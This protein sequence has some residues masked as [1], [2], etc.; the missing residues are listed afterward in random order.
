MS[1]LS[2]SL[3]ELD[4]N[5]IIYFKNKGNNE[6]LLHEALIEK[7]IDFLS[8]FS[9]FKDTNYVFFTVEPTEDNLLDIKDIL[10]DLT[11]I[12]GIVPLHTLDVRKRLTH[13]SNK[14]IKGVYYLPSD[15][16]LTELAQLTADPNLAFYYSFFIYYQRW[17]FVLACV[18]G[19]TRYHP[20]N[21]KW[22]FNKIYTLILIVWSVGFTLCWLYRKE[23]QLLAK[24]RKV[25]YFPVSQLKNESYLGD[26]ITTRGLRIKKILFFP[27]LLF[28]TGIFLFLQLSCFSLEI[29]ISQ[30]YDGSYRLL[31]SLIP[32][33]LMAI[34]TYVVNTTYNLLFVNPYVKFEGT[35]RQKESKLQKNMALVFL[36]NFAPLCITL[37]LYYPLGGKFAKIWKNTIQQL[38]KEAYPLPLISK[39]FEIDITRHRSQIFYFTITNQVILLLSNVGLPWYISRASS[40][41]SNSRLLDVSKQQEVIDESSKVEK[42]LLTRTDSYVQNWWGTF[43]VNGNIQKV[44]IQ[45]GFVM[46]FSSLWPMMPAYFFLFNLLTIRAD[47]WLGVMKCTP[48]SIPNIIMD[49]TDTEFNSENCMST[50]NRILIFTAWL[51]SELNSL[52][53]LMFGD[54]QLV[55]L[56][57]ADINILRYFK[58]EHYL[59]RPNGY[60]IFQYI[61]KFEPVITLVIFIV[62]TFRTYR[63]NSSQ[64][65]IDSHTAKSE[66]RK[67]SLTENITNDLGTDN[68]ASISNK[69]AP[70][71]IEQDRKNTEKDSNS[72]KITSAVQNENDRPNVG[73][74]DKRI[75][76]HPETGA[77]DLEPL[78]LST[79]E[80]EHRAVTPQYDMSRPTESDIKKKRRF[81]LTRI[82]SKFSRPQSMNMVDDQ[83]SVNEYSYINHFQ[84][85]GKVHLPATLRDVNNDNRKRAKSLS[86]TYSWR[87][88]SPDALA[89][90]A[91]AAALSRSSHGGT[92]PSSP[93]NTIPYGTY[94]HESVISPSSKQRSF[95]KDITEQTALSRKAPRYYKKGNNAYRD[96]PSNPLT[97]N[98]KTLD[99]KHTQGIRKQHF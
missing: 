61:L 11:F 81:S 18:G 33:I 14:V 79:P 93:V 75:E 31:L 34:F 64:T 1:K 22:E 46:L 62:Q 59:S 26:S 50:W 24:L 96:G 89:A 77:V 85:N 60:S 3:S 45:I 57:N 21:D 82:L 32:T 95:Q 8:R 92:R 54:S 41:Q 15:N 94:T 71:D 23:P 35:S 9:S 76:V 69:K 52:I 84:D 56:K 20:L 70:I 29:F 17:L 38:L 36:V 48:P 51:G 78:K 73:Q 86:S 90:E 68:N 43:D 30:L 12:E 53:I 5:F 83:Y 42:D 87:S 58:E 25:Q 28:F 40:K 49:C 6:Q 98:E 88:G 44:V 66:E 37:F 55:S 47:V 39:D 13:F 74:Q 10:N 4:P 2:N 27:I 65:K 72:A 99:Y 7:K 63:H 97:E 67:Q 16:E 19:F 91:A 80:E